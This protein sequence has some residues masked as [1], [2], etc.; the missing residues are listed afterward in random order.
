MS[1]KLKTEDSKS[2]P[3]TIWLCAAVFIQTSSAAE[4]GFD[5]IELSTPPG[6]TLVDV[7]P[8][9]KLGSEGLVWTRL[10]DAQGNTLFIFEQDTENGVSSCTDDCAQNFPPVL[11]LPDAKATGDWTL[12]KRAEGLQ[13]AYQGKPL[14]RYAKETR[15]HE[16][17]DAIE[18]SENQQGQQKDSKASAPLLPGGSQVARYLPDQNL[19]TPLNIRLRNIPVLGG[20]GLVD[21]QGMTLYS[22]GENIT[23]SQRICD[24]NCERQWTPILAAGMS[25]PVGEFTLVDRDDGQRQWAWKNAPLYRFQGDRIPGDINGSRVNSD[26]QS[27]E[28]NGHVAVL[29]RHFTPANI[30][31]G[32]DVKFGRFLATAQGL[33]LYMRKPF[34]VRTTEETIYRRGK[35]IGTGACDIQ[36][37]KNWKPFGVPKDAV[38]QGYWE[39]MVRDDGFRQWAYKGF[40]LYTYVSDQPNGVVTAHFTM[41]YA[42]GDSGY[43]KASEAAG[44]TDLHF[45][46]TGF[47]WGIAKP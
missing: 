1:K 6:I 37:Q 21:A 34:E 46:P 16:V 9:L 14:Y 5:N 47:F 41:D 10:G 32:H 39:I 7:V 30:E 18:A 3:Y 23:E 8:K 12:V 42:V 4:I 28:V 25:N 40:A 24:Q 19:Q 35:M 26:G 17:I 27:A 31:L 29:I 20:A 2:L 44:M 33:P 38:A 43:Y 11:A 45:T 36:C 13:W 15:L 22:L